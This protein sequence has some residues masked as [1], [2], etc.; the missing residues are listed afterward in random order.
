MTSLLPVIFIK[1]ILLY[2]VPYRE[3]VIVTHLSMT[4]LVI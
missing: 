1:G 4:M 2:D 3:K